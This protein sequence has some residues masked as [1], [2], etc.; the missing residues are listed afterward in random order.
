LGNQTVVG[1]E[2]LGFRF[3]DDL[4][5]VT[6]EEYTAAG[7]KPLEWRR[8]TNAYRQLKRDTRY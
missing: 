5:T 3:G 2:N 8:V 6:A 4:S 7:F 1:L